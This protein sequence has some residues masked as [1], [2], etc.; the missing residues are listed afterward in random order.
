[1]AHVLILGGGTTGVSAA[2][3]LAQ[4]GVRSTIVDSAPCIGGLPNELACKGDRECVRCDV[5]LSTDKV[6]MAVQSELV[7]F[8]KDSKLDMLERDLGKYKA[9]VSRSSN[10]IDDSKCTRCGRCLD[11][12]PSD[13]MIRRE[14]R[15]GVFYRIDP[16]RCLHESNGCTR[17]ADACAPSAIDL[18]PEEETAEYEADAVLVA[19]GAVPYDPTPDRRLGYGDIEGVVTSLDVERGLNRMDDLGRKL[20][21]G[22]VKKLC[23]V[24]CVGSRDPRIGSQ[25][26][27]KVCCKYSMKIAKLVRAVSPSTEITIFFMDWRPTDRKDDLLAWASKERGVRAVRSRPSEMIRGDDGSPVV[28][29]ALPGDLEV[30]EEAFDLVV[31]SLGL[32]PSNDSSEIA[33]MFGARLNP[34][35]FFFGEGKQVRMFESKGVFFAGTCTGPK[36]IEESSMDGAIAASKIF[37]YLEAAE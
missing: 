6:A 35:G 33:G 15:E 29:Y 16:A 17:C 10:A 21:S 9:T 20:L 13:A 7:S 32:R 31:L 4:L 2:L 23:M 12:C 18:D 34:H 11:G 3:T 30:E 5:C 36:D 26:C 24:Q 8:V 19:T 25:L 28:R 37:R 1:V 22:S 14:S 27:S